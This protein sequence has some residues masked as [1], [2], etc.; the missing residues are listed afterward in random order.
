MSAPNDIP[1]DIDPLLR[2]AFRWVIRLHSG[3][4][5]SDDALSIKQWREQT[6]DHETAF[7]EAVRLWRGAGQGARMLADKPFQDESLPFQQKRRVAAGLVSR[8]SLIGG[9]IAASAAGYAAFQPPLGL[10]PSIKELTADYRTAKGERRNVVLSQDLS[11]ELNTQTS[12]AVRSTESRPQIE[13]LSGEAAVAANLDKGEP[14]VVVAASGRTTARRANFNARCLD[15]IVSISCVN[16]AV[17]VE[18]DGRSI[19]LIGGQRV[20]YSAAEGLQA[21]IQADAEAVAWIKGLLIVRDRPL[22]SVVEEVNRYRSGRI[23]VM[24]AQLGSRMITG[25]FHLNQLGDFVEQVRLLFQASVRSLPG[26][27]VLLS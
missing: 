9:A 13:I 15:G 22:A 7:R 18:L 21:P 19:R 4:A 6:P 12:I 1:P 10:W 3:D 27:I 26:G 16:G 14:V 17:D 5:T 23:I 8:R 2:E 11:F 20:S 24:N 25:T